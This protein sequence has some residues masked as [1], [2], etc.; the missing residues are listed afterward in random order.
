[1]SR[2]II[3]EFFKKKIEEG[4]DVETILEWNK[5]LCYMFPEDIHESE[6]VF[7]SKRITELEEKIK[8][9]KVELMEAKH[10][11]NIYDYGLC[12]ACRDVNKTH[13]LLNNDF[14]IEVLKNAYLNIARTEL[15]KE[16]EE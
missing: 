7:Q 5:E 2:A 3:K 11:L 13:K 6:V 1:M 15:Q 12:E 10:N 8:G 16:R 14:G 4:G 9:L